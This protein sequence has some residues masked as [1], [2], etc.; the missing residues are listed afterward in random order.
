VQSDEAAVRKPPDC[1]GS[2]T[3][4]GWS[5]PSANPR[6]EVSVHIPVRNAAAA[7]FGLKGPSLETLLTAYGRDFSQ[8]KEARGWGPGFS[9]AISGLCVQGGGLGIPTAC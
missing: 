2:V 4:G 8:S 9:Q 5:W 7:V 6:A 3:I 1:E